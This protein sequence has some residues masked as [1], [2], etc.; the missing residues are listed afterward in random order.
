M[1]ETIHDYPKRLQTKLE[2]IEKSSISNAN[3]R[4]IAGFK[5]ECLIQGLSIGRAMKY[6]YYLETLANWLEMDFNKA[7]K[8]EIR[9]LVGKIEQSHYAEATKKELRICVKKLYKWILETDDYPELVRWIRPHTKKIERLKLPEEMLTEAEINKLISSA[10]SPRDKAFVSTLYESGCRI[11][12]LLFLRLRNIKFDQYGAFLLIPPMKTGSRRVR[13][14][15]SVPYLTE[16]INRHPHKNN[17]NEYIWYSQKKKVMSYGRVYGLLDR[18]GKKAGIKKKLNPHNFRHSRA[19]YLANHLT[20]AQ[21]KEY[22][23]W[24]QGSDMAAIYVHLSGR[25]V[26]NAILKVYGKSTEQISQESILTPKECQRCQQ[27]NPSENKFCSRC[28]IPLDRETVIKVLENDLQRK[29]ADNLLDKALENPATRAII[30]K[31]LE[32]AIGKDKQS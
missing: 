11:S 10:Q 4:I 30:T 9:N 12:E 6:L 16:W 2:A 23:G 14:V 32:E 31:I 20:E 5:D 22:F 7:S 21:M 15:T 17:P 18:L 3:K 19:T 13:I 8:P 26:D 24:T 29:E 25:D 27:T 28:G 1:K